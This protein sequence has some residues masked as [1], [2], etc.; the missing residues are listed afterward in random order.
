MIAPPSR[1]LGNEIDP[2]TNKT[3]LDLIEKLR[4]RKQETQEQY[5]V[6]KSLRTNKKKFHL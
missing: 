3:T 4:V 5:R 6:M 2:I 1:T